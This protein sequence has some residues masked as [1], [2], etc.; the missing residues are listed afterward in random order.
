MQQVLGDFKCCMNF[1]TDYYVRPWAQKL[2]FLPNNEKWWTQKKGT[3]AS[4]HLK[5]LGILHSTQ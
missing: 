1:K 4:K 5:M 3:S 2:S